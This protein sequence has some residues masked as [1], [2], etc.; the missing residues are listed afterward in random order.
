MSEYLAF[1]V[2]ALA[3]FGGQRGDGG[4]PFSRQT[5][6]AGRLLDSGAPP[7]ANLI[8][9]IVPGNGLVRGNVLRGKG[10]LGRR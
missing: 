5:A 3:L 7:G 8:K 1:S 9:R 10:I 6:A 4:I 2:D